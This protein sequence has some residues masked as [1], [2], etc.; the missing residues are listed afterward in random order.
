MDP[1][2]PVGA[3]HIAGASGAEEPLSSPMIPFL[4]HSCS[5]K[6]GEH[7]FIDLRYS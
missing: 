2:L 3:P 7:V 1:P 5:L 6:A 4:M